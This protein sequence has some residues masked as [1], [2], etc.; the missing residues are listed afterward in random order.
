MTALTVVPR[1]A[2]LAA[3]TRASGL[4]EGLREDVARRV[5]DL[6]GNSLAATGEVSASA[7]TAVV[8]GWGGPEDATAIGTGL[9]VPAAAAA[10]V[11]GTLAH[12]LDLDDTHLPSTTVGGPVSPCRARSAA[13]TPACAAQPQC[14]RLT[15][16]P[17]RLASS[18]PDPMD[19]AIPAA[20]AIRSASSP[21]TVAA[22]TAA[23]TAPQIEVACCPRS[24]NSELPS[25]AS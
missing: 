1:L 2:V 11:N 4:P 3:D 25:L 12:S 8:R 17:V 21:P 15:V 5:L 20:C 9:R 6:L 22:A 16:P 13:T 14:T 18:S 24:K 23:P 10:L 7:V 19:A